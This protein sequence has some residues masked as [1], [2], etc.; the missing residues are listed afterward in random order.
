MVINDAGIKAHFAD[1]SN[2]VTMGGV[3]LKKGQLAD[4]HWPPNDPQ[5]PE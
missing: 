2:Q 1:S 4:G 3:T 5:L